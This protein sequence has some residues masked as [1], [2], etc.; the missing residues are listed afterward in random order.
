NGHW[1]FPLT[2]DCD[3]Q[4]S[5]IEQPVVAGQLPPRPPAMPLAGSG[6]PV[7]TTMIEWLPSVVDR[8]FVSVTTV[9]VA[10]LAVI[11]S[12]SVTGGMSLVIGLLTADTIAARTADAESG[13]EKITGTLPAPRLELWLTSNVTIGLTPSLSVNV[14]PG[15]SPLPGHAVID[16]TAGASVTVPQFALHDPHAF[17][18]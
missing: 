9:P 15:V 4:S 2:H 1:H 10:P 14:S 18:L 6:P 7:T 3:K 16:P 12:A 5:L 13:L 17:V 8:L 11:A